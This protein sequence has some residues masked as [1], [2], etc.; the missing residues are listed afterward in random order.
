MR[1]RLAASAAN[2]LGLDP[3]GNIPP[4][5]DCGVVAV[6]KLRSATER[7]TTWPNRQTAAPHGVEGRVG[8]LHADAQGCC[9][10]S[11]AVPTCTVPQGMHVLPTVRPDYSAAS[12]A[13][14]GVLN[15]FK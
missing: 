3:L 4:S 7:N 1:C 8:Q 2:T 11:A 5:A 15:T 13:A 9:A 14:R 12:F 6:R 10:Q